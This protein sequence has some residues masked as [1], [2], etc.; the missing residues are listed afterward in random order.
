[1]DLTVVRE[2]EGGDLAGRGRHG[3]QRPVLVAVGEQQPGQRVGIGAVGFR[4]AAGD[5][6]AVATDLQRV[7]RVDRPV[8]AQCG[9]EQAVGG[10]DRDRDP[11]QPCVPFP[12]SRA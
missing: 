6:L 2:A 11:P 1:V 3:G 9:D 8:A 4:P 7:E 12:S 5:P 10:F